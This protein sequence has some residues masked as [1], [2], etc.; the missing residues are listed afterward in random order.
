MAGKPMTRGLT[1][2]LRELAKQVE[3]MA[4]D[5]SEITR[6]HALALLLWKKALGYKALE[7]DRKNKTMEEVYHPPEAWAIQL[8]Y[9]RLEGR[10]AQNAPDE[11]SRMSAAE[12]VSELAKSRINSLVG[13]P[14]PPP[15]PEL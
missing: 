6:E 13:V 14:A 10:V 15:I 2:A 7:L 3:T 9:E 12:R 8:V 5:G 11:N 1:K 4:D